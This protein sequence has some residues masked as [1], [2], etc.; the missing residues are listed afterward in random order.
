MIRAGMLVLIGSWLPLI[1]VSIIDPAANP[2][3]LNLLGA[4]GKIVGGV[5]VGLGFLDS[6]FRSAD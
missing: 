1:A 5:A 6:V 3:E 2:I 4:A